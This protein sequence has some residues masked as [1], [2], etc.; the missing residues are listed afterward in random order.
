M[1]ILIMGGNGFIAREIMID[2]LSQG[3]TVTACVRNRSMG[4]WE[5]ER[6]RY[7]VLDF[8]N[9]TN[10]ADWA[11]YLVDQDIV[12]NCVG[13]FQTRTQKEMWD[14]HCHAPTAL[15]DACVSAKITKIIHL[16]ALG[17]DHSTVDYAQS[18]LAAESHLQQLA[19]ASVIIRPSFVYGSSSYGGSSLFRGLASL[20]FFIFLPGNG[21]QLLQ[22]VHL[23]D[24]VKIVR[25][26]LSLQGKQILCAVGSEKLSLR[27]ILNKLRFWLG[28]G[29]AKNIKIPF[30][31]IKIAAKCGDF[32]RNAPL[33]STGVK[34]MVLDN[35]VSDDAFETL[36]K[37]VG[38]APRGFSDGLR[39]M[40]S[41]VQD[42]WHARLFFLRPLMRLS[43]GFLWIATGVVSA[44]FAKTFSYP[45]LTAAH[46]SPIWH[47]FLCYSASLMDCALGLALICNYRVKLIGSVQLL[48]ML[49]FTAIITVTMPVCWLYP[50]GPV[51]KNIPLFIATLI[52]MAIESDR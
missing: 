30:G 8:Q 11:P 22:P 46:I 27:T 50:F 5:T 38:F 10:A 3:H 34:L 47:S 19:I 39:G 42:R 23:H 24:L 29:S 49:I 1:N 31:W 7:V 51:T 6:L 13:V 35:V 43:L 15:F 2:L 18:K 14:I 33:S 25:H 4:D 32:L 37:T 45:L 44:V 17:I 36:T 41:G 26:A 21:E 40:V 12:I 28:F 20:P 9:H 16:S 52:M 48:F